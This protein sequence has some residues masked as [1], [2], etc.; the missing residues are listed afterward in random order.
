MYTLLLAALTGLPNAAAL[1]HAPDPEIQILT[2]IASAEP[3][4]KPAANDPENDAAKTPG[5]R[6]WRV[7]GDQPAPTFENGVWRW[8][9][10]RIPTA[11]HEG[12]AAPTPP[13]A[14]EI[15]SY[16][17]VRRA[18]VRMATPMGNASGTGFYPLFGHIS[19]NDIPM[20]APVEMDFSRTDAARG[21]RVEWTM[22]FLYEH[23][24]QGELGDD[25]SDARVDVVDV[26]P[27]TVI[28]LGA[29]GFSRGERIAQAEGKLEAWLKESGEWR[30]AGP[31]RWLGYNGP[32]MPMSRQWSEVQI[33]IER[34][35]TE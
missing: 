30:R 25:P 22:G 9:D 14:I 21:E 4:T 19:R 28:S 16:P 12:Y 31:T 2:P 32:Q 33:P 24:R 15:K 34:I 8:G 11:L 18:E 17:V 13:G 3:E 29:Q 35:P 7:V 1:A 10:C 6:V 5:D 27:M 26:P 20:T 23:T